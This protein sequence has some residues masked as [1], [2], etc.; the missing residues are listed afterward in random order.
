[1]E[2]L[3]ASY[4][5]QR[6]IADLL[7]DIRA[8]LR[9]YLVIGEFQFVTLALYVIHTH[10]I[11]VGSEEG[12]YPY[13]TCYLNITSPVKRSGKTRVLEVLS[14]LV[15]RPWFC[16]MTTTAALVRRIQ[17]EQPT[18]LLDETDRAFTGDRDYA[19][20]LTGILNAGY[21]RKGSVWMCE[22]KALINRPGS[23]MCFVRKCFQ[24]SGTNTCQ[25]RCLIAR[26]PSR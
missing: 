8:A 26:F 3:T 4:A 7:D 6:K 12:L 11:G 21:T 13:H 2:T 18:L 10:A 14:L 25:I 19:N 5:A 17:N 15:G 1:M 16:S 23:G 9:R 22:G 24:G 20:K